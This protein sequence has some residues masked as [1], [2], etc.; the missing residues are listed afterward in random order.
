MKRFIVC[1]ILFLL[2]FSC[3]HVRISKDMLVEEK[4]RIG[5][6][7]FENEKFHKAIPYYLEVVLD[8]K[9]GFTSEAQLKLADSYFNQNKFLDAR[10]E[11]EEMIRLFKNYEGIEKAYF[12]IGI[13]YFEESMSAHYT[14]EETE[15][16]LN[17]FRSFIEKF[18]LS[19]RKPLAF[20]YV[21]K[22][23]QKF[24]EKKYYNGYAY[25]KLFDYSSA[26]MYFNEV[27]SLGMTNE[28]DR[29]S[30]Y[31]SAKIYIRRTNKPMAELVME[32]LTVKYPDA[33]ETQKI[34]GLIS[35][36]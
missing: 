5:N 21:A 14:Q 8:R 1:G 27:V 6:E 18:P 15:L 22:C 17:T 36:L 7:Y 31:Y 10:F 11:Y 24:A 4:M 3:S 19:E 23:E 2:L 9:S 25:Y 34:V 13:C 20:E 28:I 12:R 16:A 30:L 35:K 32:K 26:L 33:V 29:K